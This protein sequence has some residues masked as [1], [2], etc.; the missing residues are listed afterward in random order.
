MASLF[1]SL[2]RTA[3]T[4]ISSL[5]LFYKPAELC[6]LVNK[7]SGASAIASDLKY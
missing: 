3:I 6:A 2:S 7:T 5:K 4:N 1:T